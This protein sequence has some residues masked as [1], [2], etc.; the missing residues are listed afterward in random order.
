[1]EPEE[2]KKPQTVMKSQEEQA[3]A[4]SGEPDF[5]H[6]F[7]VEEEMTVLGGEIVDTLPTTILSEEISF[8][9]ELDADLETDV[10]TEEITSVLWEEA[11]DVLAA[12]EATDVL[13]VDGATDV[14]TAVEVT[15]VLAAEEA[16]DKK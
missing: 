13:M 10:L 9:S 5:S 15:N 12:E 2:L 6:V 16:T 7:Q 11:T 14:L 1:M 3:I 4:S 8:S